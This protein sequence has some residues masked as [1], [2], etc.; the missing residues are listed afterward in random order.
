VPIGSPEANT[1]TLTSGTGIEAIID[2]VLQV[3]CHSD[4]SQE[5][6]LVM[7]RAHKGTNGCKDILKGICELEGVSLAKTVLD[8]SINNE[9]EGREVQITSM[10]VDVCRCMIE[11]ER[12][13]RIKVDGWE[14]QV[15]STESTE[16]DVRR[17]MIGWYADRAWEGVIQM[18][19]SRQ[20]GG[21]QLPVGEVLR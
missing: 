21:I 5:L 18:R 6:V 13:E 10:D 16:V 9:V 1:R 15:T 3:F 14:V 8:I 2:E 19:E 7:V 20:K 12:Y 4:L 17:R 11:W